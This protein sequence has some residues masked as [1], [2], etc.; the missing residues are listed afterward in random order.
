MLYTCMKMHPTT[1]FQEANRV[2]IKKACNYCLILSLLTLV[3]A[4]F[5]PAIPTY[6]CNFLVAF[7]TCLVL[8][9]SSF[10]LLRDLV[11]ARQEMNQLLQQS[12]QEQQLLLENAE[13]MITAAH[14]DPPQHG[15]KY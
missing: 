9:F 8:F 4:L 15:K 11:K 6:S 5:P 1:C 13:L 14:R 10:S 7:Y 12:I 2:S 3:C